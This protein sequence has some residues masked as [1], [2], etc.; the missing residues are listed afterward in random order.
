MTDIV[1]LPAQ[2]LGETYLQLHTHYTNMHTEMHTWPQTDVRTQTHACPN[3]RACMYANINWDIQAESRWI[4]NSTIMYAM[5]DLIHFVYLCV[6]LSH[7]LSFIPYF[8]W[9]TFS[10]FPSS[11]HEKKQRKPLFLWGTGW[12]SSSCSKFRLSNSDRELNSFQSIPVHAP[13]RGQQRIRSILFL[14]LLITNNC[15]T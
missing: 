4:L 10:R 12:I 6:A 3:L 2:Q 14:N 8:L 13:L 5:Y 15:N 7:L 11:F 1:L 9:F